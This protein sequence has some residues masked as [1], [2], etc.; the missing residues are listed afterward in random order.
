MDD[1]RQRQ[2]VEARLG[3]LQSVRREPQVLGALGDPQQARPVGARMHDAPDVRE[4]H[5]A[6]EV[7]RHHRDAGGATVHL[8]DLPDVREAPDAPLGATEALVPGRHLRRRF[9]AGASRRLLLDLLHLVEADD[10]V[11]P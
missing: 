9:L 4:A 10:L 1:R 8:V 7:A 2:F 6:A 3:G 11:H 5:G